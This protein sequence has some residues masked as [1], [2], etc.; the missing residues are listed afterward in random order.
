MT[1]VISESQKTSSLDFIKTEI[2]SD[3]PMEQSEDN[4]LASN[5]FGD[6]DDSVGGGPKSDTIKQ[7]D[8][9]LKAQLSN[10]QRGE[11]LGEG[12]FGKVYQGMY[13]GKTNREEDIKQTL[14]CKENPTQ[15][16]EAGRVTKD[17]DVGFDENSR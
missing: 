9:E 12:T 3:Y 17:K 8:Q 10:V 16:Q 15:F 14:P 6:N 11:L 5:E 13:K 2:K 4:N 1:E 7:I